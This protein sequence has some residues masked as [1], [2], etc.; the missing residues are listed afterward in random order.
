MPAK[1]TTIKSNAQNIIK[2]RFQ[3]LL[4]QVALKDKEESTINFSQYINIM[5]LHCVHKKTKPEN[6]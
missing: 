5:Q 2:A 1:Y 6:F 4:D 3:K